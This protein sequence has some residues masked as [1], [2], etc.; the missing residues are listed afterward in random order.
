MLFA[1][2]VYVRRHRCRK[3]HGHALFWQSGDDRFN[4]VNKAHIEHF[5]RF[6]KHQVF[7]VGGIERSSFKMVDNS[8]RRADNRVRFLLELFFLMVEGGLA[9]NCGNFQPFKATDIKNIFLN[10][11]GKFPSGGNHQG[12]WFVRFPVY[13]LTNGY[14]KSRRFAAAG[15]GFD[16]DIPLGQQN[17]YDLCLHLRWA[18]VIQHT[19]GFEQVFVQFKIAEICVFHFVLFQF[20][21]NALHEFRGFASKVT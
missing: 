17:R 14:G 2:P 12:L 16:N 10:L 18:F 15:L 7:D 19:N 6:V 20:V 9:E 8:P 21:G 5:V 13:H 1:Q 11:N 4:I 3:Q